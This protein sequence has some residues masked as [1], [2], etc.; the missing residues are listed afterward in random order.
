MFH[1]ILHQPEIPQN[2]GSIGR[3]CVS[4][5][6]RLHLIHPLGFDTSDA[7]VRRAGLDYWKHLD[8]TEYEHWEDFLARGPA[9]SLWLF[10]TK[11][12]RRHTQV[13][14]RDGDG[15]VFG[16]ETSGLPPEM[17]EAFR[18]RLVKIPMPG[19]FHRSLNLAQSA[20]VGLYEALRQ[21]LAW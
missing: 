3:L 6:A 13:P 18:D 1:L 21:T 15:L 9:A 4:T 2:T 17:V 7:A 8:P 5:G 16:R 20:A 10:S 11:G 12:D 19:D 14:W